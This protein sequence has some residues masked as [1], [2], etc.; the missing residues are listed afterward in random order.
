MMRCTK[1]DKL[2]TLVLC[3]D[4]TQETISDALR[5]ERVLADDLAKFLSMFVNDRTFTETWAQAQQV[6]DEY[7]KSRGGK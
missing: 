6:L 4:C 7:A 3:P 5:A 2:H 1:H